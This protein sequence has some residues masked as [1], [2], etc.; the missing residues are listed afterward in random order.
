MP[1]INQPSTLRVPL[2]ESGDLPKADIWL[3]P[4]RLTR[5]EF[6]RRYNAMPHIKKA[7]LV[8]GVVYMASPVRSRSHGKPHALL[9]AWLTD[10]WLDTSG[11]DL[12]IEATVRLDSDNEPQPDTLL[13]I[14]EANGGQ[15]R[16]S[17]DDY[18]EGAP[19]LVVEIAASS[20]AYDLHDKKC[21]Y[22]RNSVREY[23]VWQVLE[24]KL[25]LFC[26]QDSEFI[27]LEPDDQ[28]IIRRKS[29]SGIMVSG[30]RS[31]DGKYD[32]GAGSIAGRIKFSRTSGICATVGRKIKG[33]K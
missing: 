18:I 19:E 7:E 13:R 14:E 21:A 15:S 8:E 27:S 28:G 24:Q 1:P 5:P 23:L 33:L 16:I 29:V 32:A 4:D 31:I 22:R 3:K 12:N 11:T 30:D 25:D 20:V 9:L 10:Y 6:E 2:L 26:L 17:E